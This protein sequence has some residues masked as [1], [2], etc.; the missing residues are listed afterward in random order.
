MSIEIFQFPKKASRDDL[1]LAL[2]ARSFVEGENLFFPGPS[3][4][5]HLFWSEQRDFLS[6]SGVDA[7]VMPLDAPGK[8]AWHTTNDWWLRTRTSI[9]AS[10]FDQRY[11]NET[12]RTVRHSFG[13]TFYNDHFGH[14]RYI[15]ID[16]V[17][18]TPASRGLYAVFSRVKGELDSLEHVLPDEQFKVLATPSGTITEASDQTG[19]FKLAQKNDPSRVIYNALVPFLVAA[20][21]HVFR[22]TFEILL[23]YDERA[24]AVVE[25]QNRKLS[26]LD[27]VKLVRGD[28]TLERIASSWYSFQ[29]L[30]SIQKAFKEIFDVDVWKMIR[31]RRKVRSKLPMLSDAFANLIG[32]RHGVVHHF[33][34]DRELRR[35]GFLELLHLVQAI[36]GVLEIEMERRLG[37]PIGPG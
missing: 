36:V 37:V 27:G 24:R 23:K 6:T 34:I 29:N 28:V 19:I 1:V 25:G 10:T 35:E 22:E 12:V 30:D 26:Y 33:S 13:G 21:E 20:L 11:Q 31:T 16:S 14:N 8:K 2:K 17:P 7:S 4:T 9:W 15:Q 3:G 5:V 32:A 18:S